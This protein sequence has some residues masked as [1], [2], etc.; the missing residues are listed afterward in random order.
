[1]NPRGFTIVEVLIALIL[2]TVGALAL[3][4]GSGLAVRMIGRGEQLTGAA[5]L[6][7]RRIE[8]LRRQG[9]SGGPGCGGLASGSV[10]PPGQLAEQWWV[11]GSGAARTV[12]VVIGYPGR[13]ASSSDSVA[14]VIRCV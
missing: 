6:A 2:L 9:T 14:T 7:G 1:M 4:A 10:A 12:V 5:T 3:A 8:I 11:A 13:W